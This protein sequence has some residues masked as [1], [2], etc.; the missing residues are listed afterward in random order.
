M[1]IQ[2]AEVNS[3][4]ARSDAAID[5]TVAMELV[6]VTEAAAR[7]A[8]RH[9]GRGDKNAI[10]GA[11]VDVMRQCLNDMPIYGRVVVGEGEK[12]EAP[13]LYVGEELG[14]YHDNPDCPRLDIAVDPVDGTTL[15]SKGGENAISVLAVAEEGKLLRAPDIRMNKLVVGPGMDINAYALD[16]PVT[17]VL[18]MAAKQKGVRVEDLVVCM[19]DRS[20]AEPV[21]QQIRA[22]GARMKLI[23]DGDIAGA[24]MTCMPES[25]VDLFMG[26]GGAPEGVLAAAALKCMGGA[27]LGQLVPDLSRDPE[28]AWQRLEE[29]GMKDNAHDML[30]TEELA[31]G[32]VIFSATGITD[33][34]MLEGVK[35]VKGGETTHSVVMRSKTGTIRKVETFH[36]HSFV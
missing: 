25:G 29:L 11:A 35:R 27:M 28:F 33:G 31:G 22:A 13:L 7:A 16:M 14:R 30:G 8:V 17:D 34:G 26:L 9:M 6:R 20:R 12:D 3:L 5:R 4:G 10:D 2:L 1:A 32:E 23:S 19:L 36:R 15:T 18:N 24:I 21:Y